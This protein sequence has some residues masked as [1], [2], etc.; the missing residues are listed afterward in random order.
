MDRVRLPHPT[1]RTY[2]QAVARALAQVAEHFPQ[3]SDPSGWIAKLAKPERAPAM[4]VYKTAL[5]RWITLEYLLNQHLNRRVSSLE[6][7]ARGVLMSGATQLLFVDRQ[8]AYAVVNESV[9][10]ARALVRQGAGALVNAVLRRLADSVGEVVRQEPWSAG[11]D[12][13]PHD[14]GVL[15]LKQACLPDPHRLEEH[16]SI[17]TS[18]PRGLVRR[19]LERLGADV[20]VEICR[21]GVRTPPVIVHAPR[22]VDSP[23]GGRRDR[24]T[25]EPHETAGFG[26][27]HGSADQLGPFLREDPWRRVQ[28]PAAAAPVE[29][30]A[31]LEPRPSVIVDCCAGLGTK[32]RQLAVTHPEAL[33]LASDANPV[34]LEALER[35]F[36][37]HRS[38]RVLDLESLGSRLDDHP[39]DLVML[40]V[41]CSNTAVLA[42]RPEARYRFSRESLGSLTRCQ[43]E[44]ARRSIGWLRPGGHVLYSTCSLEKEENEDQVGGLEREL[45][46]ELVT[47]QLT[48]PS[49]EGWSYHDGGYFAVMR[50]P[51]AGGSSG[52][53]GL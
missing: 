35:V 36:E 3:W 47:S 14:L 49:G 18:H 22:G 5:R 19:W 27:W 17:A 11:A 1:T 7:M 25:I 16:L 31:T 20:A 21:C 23:S 40:D 41:P 15:R 12:R 53:A 10:L 2:R 28:D 42:R 50:K 51:A 13:L 32:T 6:P 30:T 46:L 29:A 48:L 24:W 34:R 37:G 38:V 43:V 39:A 44:I 8:P 9:K 26:I 52:R 45:G 33:V 4:A